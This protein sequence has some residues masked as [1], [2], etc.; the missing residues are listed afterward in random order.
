MTGVQ[1][2]ALPIWPVFGEACTACAVCA[3]FCPEGVISRRGGEM[4]V[5]LLHCKGCGICA[6]VCPV[7]D[8]IAMEEVSA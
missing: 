3:L 6:A 7:R 1:T 4:A 8:A 2:C 5:D